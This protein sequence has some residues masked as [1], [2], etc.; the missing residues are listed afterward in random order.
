MTSTSKVSHWEAVYTSKGDQEVSWY[1]PHL[2]TSLALI[3]GTGVRED[4]TIVDVGGGSSTLVD[5]LVRMGHNRV[6]VLDLAAPALQRARGRLGVRRS[7]PGWV[8]ADA[9][10]LPLASRSVDLW[11]DRAVF[12]FLTEEGA[13]QRYVEE[14]RRVVRP[15]KHVIVGTFGPDGPSRC[16]G[17]VVERYAPEQ[18]HGTFGPDF[19]LL[20]HREERHQ[21]PFGTT[22]QFVYC[23]CRRL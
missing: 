18:L 14:V 20:Q 9:L 19:T 17:L 15:G 8:V 2:E 16:S 1:A 5:D 6:L 11:H 3:A 12:H 13:R 23:Y 4:A 21:T 10:A 22:Q 7:T